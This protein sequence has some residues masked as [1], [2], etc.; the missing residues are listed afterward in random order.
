MIRTLVYR[1]LRICSDKIPYRVNFFEKVFR[2][3]GYPGNAI[4]KCFKRFL[5][6]THFV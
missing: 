4:D 6:N 2:K 3:N 5:D 1:C